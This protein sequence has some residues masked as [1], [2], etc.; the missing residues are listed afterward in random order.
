MS[1]GSASSPPS[2][3]DGP[4]SD[5][6]GPS[7]LAQA[8][9]FLGAIGGSLSVA[10]G[11][12]VLVGPAPAMGLLVPAPAPDRPAAV[13]EAVAA[14]PLTGLVVL[15]WPVGTALI[16]GYGGLAAL[17]RQR[18]YVLGTGVLLVFLL[19]LGP[20]AMVAALPAAVS[21]LGAWALLAGDHVVRARRAARLRSEETKP[22]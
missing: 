12:A 13:V 5:P 3:A 22:P 2:A 4:G 21:L 17:R 9:R 15:A 1:T 8:G 10:A 16:G 19:V 7:L 18:R 20:P 6:V 14:D 11:V